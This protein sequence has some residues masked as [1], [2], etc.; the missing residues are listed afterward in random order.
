MPGF[1]YTAWLLFGIFVGF[2]ICLTFA[3]FVR[4]MRRAREAR[5]KQAKKTELARERRNS[6]VNNS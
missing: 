4:A 5:E 3:S 6:S 2:W 1:G